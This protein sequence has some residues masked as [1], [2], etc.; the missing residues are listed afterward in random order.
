MMSN[1]RRTIDS[2]PSPRKSNFGTPIASRSSL[3]NC[4]I[5]RPIAVCSIGR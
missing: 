3:S 4:T 5:V 2:A 1:E